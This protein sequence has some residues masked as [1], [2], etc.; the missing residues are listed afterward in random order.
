MVGRLPGP[1]VSLEIHDPSL[2]RM[3]ATTGGNGL[4][5]A[6][7]EGA[8]DTRDLASL[9]ELASIHMEPGTRPALPQSLIDATHAAWRLAGRTW[10]SRGPVRDIVHHYDLGN[11]FYSSWLDPSMTYSSAFF[12]SP[13]MT[14]EQ[15]QLE[16]YRRLAAATGIEA[17][18]RVLEI[19]SG[20]G[21]FARYLAADIGADVTT[22]T[23][24]REQATWVEKLMAQEGLSDRVEVRLEDFLETP[25]TFDAV[26]SIEMIES[27]PGNRW[28]EYFRTLAARLAPGGRIG[29]Q[30]IT[31]ADHHWEVSNA[32]PDFVRRY[33]F[34]GGQVPAPKVLRRL[35]ADNRL[36][37]QS[38]ERFGRS[39]AKTLAG[40][41]ENFELAWPEIAD[42][43]FD[44]RFRRMWT[45][46]LAYCEGGF[47][48]GRVDVGQIVLSG[49][50][51]W[52]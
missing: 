29:L 26:V 41:A 15:A 25:G 19:G 30:A 33:I 28:P 34:P 44:D 16:K 27:I 6:Y 24:S 42:M 1:E 5:D 11:D 3:V 13:D 14:L 36:T 4:A 50:P 32:N 38:E 20:W 2:L 43:G 52:R 35:A 22:V 48:S 49:D 47:R 40:W 37:W 39:Y 31:V 7:I 10:S 18:A 17:G 23:V 51:S 45:Y 8:F 12:A 9:I 21:G 46:Y